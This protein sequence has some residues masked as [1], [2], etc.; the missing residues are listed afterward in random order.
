LFA[1][2]TSVDLLNKADVE[3]FLSDNRIIHTYGCVHAGIPTEKD[4]IDTHAA[5]SLER[6]FG[7]PRDFSR[8]FEPRK[9]FLDRCLSAS[10]NLRTIDPHDKEED[11]A[12]LAVARQWIDE[13]N[14]I[15]ILGYGFDPQN[16]RRIALEPTLKE[17]SDKVV[18]FTNFCDLNTINKK[19]S[20]LCFG[21][22]SHFTE[23]IP[24]GN[25]VGR[26]F[27][28][29]IRNVYEALEKDFN[30]LEDEFIG[31]TKI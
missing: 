3:H 20:K 4:F 25:P 21:D 16:N 5:V 9:T 7:E 15:Y 11:E 6:S 19:A 26:Y 17:G 2:L 27:E 8:D 12:S 30:A 18:M 10:R 13:A 14:V 24:W 29:S 23:Q 28:K 31:G 1:A 22:L